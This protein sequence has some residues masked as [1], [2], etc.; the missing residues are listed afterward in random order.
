M[1]ICVLPGTQEI[2]RRLKGVYDGGQG[3]AVAN[4]YAQIGQ[5]TQQELAAPGVVIMFYQAI[6]DHV[7]D[8]ELA[9]LVRSFVPAWIDALVDNKAVAMEAKELHAKAAV[10]AQEAASRERPALLELPVTSA[11]QALSYLTCW[12][13]DRGYKGLVRVWEFKGK[14]V[15]SRGESYF[16][17]DMFQPRGVFCVYKDGTV[18]DPRG[19]FAEKR[20]T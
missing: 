3:S 1:E 14:H 10:M 4:I 20:K 2:V 11:R 8:G 5:S 17:F 16:D 6:H 15:D 18:R 12:L 19:I 7:Q 13:Q 9:T